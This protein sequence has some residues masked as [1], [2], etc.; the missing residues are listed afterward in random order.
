[1]CVVYVVIKIGIQSVR[2]RV[3][4][5]L[6]IFCSLIVERELGNKEGR[7]V[8]ER[9]FATLACSLVTTWRSERRHKLG[10]SW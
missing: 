9:P 10:R 1:M 3:L 5:K 2:V 4:P 8:E 7:V 6:G